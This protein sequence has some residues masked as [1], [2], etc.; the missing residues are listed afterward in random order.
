[1]GFDLTI[2]LYKKEEL[3]LDFLQWVENFINDKNKRNL[4]IKI[5]D[6]WYIESE[7]ILGVWTNIDILGSEFCNF[8]FGFYVE[9][10]SSYVITKEALEKFF[11]SLYSNQILIFDNTDLYRVERFID[12]R[13][14]IKSWFKQGLNFDD[15]IIILTE[16]W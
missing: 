12:F 5:P 3:S 2:D 11:D 13:K 14:T 9:N 1:M 10:G 7:D 6:Y 15:Y 16:S 8:D 4:G